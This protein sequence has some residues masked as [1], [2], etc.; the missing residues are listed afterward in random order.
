[1]HG[2]SS[3]HGTGMNGLSENIPKQYGKIHL[4]NIQ[5]ANWKM[6]MKIVDLPIKIYK[7]MVSFH[8]F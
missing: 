5:K 4:V 3:G 2:K 1:L 8:S 7:N 6:A